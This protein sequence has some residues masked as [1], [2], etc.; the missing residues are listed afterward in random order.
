MLRTIGASRRTLI[1]LLLTE[2]L[3][4][5]VIGTAAGLALGYGLGRAITTGGAGI[6]RQYLNMEIGALIIEPGL[7]V[8]TITLGVGVSLLSGL[9]PAWGA[10]RL[11]PLAALR[12]AALA[13][14]QVG[15]T[16]TLLGAA[17]ICASLLML[18]SGRF[19][20]LALGGLLFF[21]W[22]GAGITCACAARGRGI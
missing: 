11:T 9:L 10:S 3:L 19:A 20:L 8:T 18:R 4:Q 2:S 17:L 5:G 1:G 7:L 21:Y 15:R 12:P 22:A 14:Q 16:G 6:L 13:P